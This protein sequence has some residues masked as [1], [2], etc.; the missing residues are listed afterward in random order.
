MLKVVDKD[1]SKD[2]SKASKDKSTPGKVKEIIEKLNQLHVSPPQDVRTI[3]PPQACR[4][5]TPAQAAK[6]QASSNKLG[7]ILNC[8]FF[9]VTEN[10]LKF[11][12][13]LSKQN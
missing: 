10:L 13:F 7:G 8:W 3:S 9:R 11:I 6:T 5:K 12:D 4:T 1:E 2:E